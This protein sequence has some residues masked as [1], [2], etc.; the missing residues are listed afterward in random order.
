MLTL[1]NAGQVAV[2]LEDGND[3]DYFTD[4]LTSTTQSFSW[5]EEN[6]FVLRVPSYGVLLGVHSL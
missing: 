2:E 4:H 3:S 6:H 1:S 5:R